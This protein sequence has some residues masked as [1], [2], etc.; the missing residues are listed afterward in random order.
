MF[1]AFLETQNFYTAIQYIQ[2]A[3]NLRN[4]PN[5]ASYLNTVIIVL[6][7]LPRSSPF[8]NNNQIYFSNFI[9]ETNFPFK[10]KFIGS[11][12]DPIDTIMDEIK[13]VVNVYA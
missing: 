11:I 4:N 6:D 10:G 2:L 1:N 13:K 3:Q 8:F 7:Y 12:H 9:G 5:Y